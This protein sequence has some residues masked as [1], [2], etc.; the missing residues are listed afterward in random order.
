MKKTSVFFTILFNE[1]LNLSGLSVHDNLTDRRL[2][3]LPF[4]LISRT[5]KGKNAALILIKQVVPCTMLTE[6]RIKEK[7]ITMFLSPR[8]AM[9]QN[10]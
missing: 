7:P 1:E 6:N 9:F 2:W 8:A 3:L 4:L 10:E 5:N